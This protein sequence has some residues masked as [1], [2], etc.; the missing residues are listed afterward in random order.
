MHS[1]I[2]SKC[3]KT[4]ETRKK[5]QM[6]CSKSCANSVNTSKRKIE[7]ES[8]YSYGLN[9][10]NS[11]IL[12]LIY[13]DG[14]LSFDKHTDKFRITISMNDKDVMDKIHKI[15]TP[16][17]KLYEYK[18]P[19]GRKE[20]YSVISTNKDDI[21]FIKKIGITTRKSLSIEYPS[22]SKE[23]DRDFIRG[24]FDGDGSVYESKTITRYNDVKKEYVYKYFRFTTGSEKFAYQLQAKLLENNIESNVNKDSR[25]ESLA[26][27][28]AIYKK[29]SVYRFFEFIYNGAEIFMERKY[30]KFINMI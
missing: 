11:Y 2:C 17:K 13:S 30:N 14:C 25:I 16:N 22:I 7:D 19:K 3:N 20:T 10:I 24:Y 27:Y 12:G 21:E 5:G 15:M 28:I 6:Y 1:Y 23:Y 8:I 26:Y 9:N 4:F 18:H 29:E